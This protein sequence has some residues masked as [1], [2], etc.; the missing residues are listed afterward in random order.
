MHMKMCSHST[1]VIVRINIDRLSFSLFINIC[2]DRT[3]FISISNLIVFVPNFKFDKF[4]IRF[5]AQ[6]TL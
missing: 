3:C 1:I 6:D 2:K 4:H 5:Y